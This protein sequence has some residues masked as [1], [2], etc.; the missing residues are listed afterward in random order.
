MKRLLPMLMALAL[1]G[2]FDSPPQQLHLSFGAHHATPVMILAFTVNDIQHSAVPQ[3][4]SG[5]ADKG[6]PR[7]GGTGI[8]NSWPGDPS[9]AVVAATW[10]ELLTNRAYSTEIELA[11][12]DLPR[13]ASKGGEVKAVFGAHGLIIL[14]GDSVETMP[15]YIDLVRACGQRVPDLD[16]DFTGKP[17]AHARLSEALAQ[18]RPATPQTTFCPEPVQ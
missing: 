3:V 6:Y 16:E 2:C 10:V 17:L 9:K 18:D 11:T 7:T 1:S 5:A 8:Y 13:S 14:A 12:A 15:E 4:V